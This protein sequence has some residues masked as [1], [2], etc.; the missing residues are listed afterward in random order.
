MADFLKELFLPMISSENIAGVKSLSV[1][2]TDP[3]VL[4][5]CLLIAA[6][7]TVLLAVISSPGLAFICQHTAA[8]TKKPFFDKYAKQL[9]TMATTLGG[10]FFTGIAAG[11]IHVAMQQPVIFEGPFRIPV[12]VTLVGVLS[13]FALLFA[14]TITWR[15]LRT[16]RGLHKLIGVLTELSMLTV[17]FLV[18]GVLRGL[19][20]KGHPVSASDSAVEQLLSLYIIPGSG[21]FW[22]LFMQAFVYGYGAAG[23]LGCCYL[24]LRRNR[25]DF[26]RDYYKFALSLSSVWAMLGTL[27]ALI[28]AGFMIWQYMPFIGSF[29]PQNVAFWCVL[30]VVVLPVLACCC[31]VTVVRAENPLRAKPAIFAAVPLA[32]G[33]LAAQVLLMLHFAEL[34]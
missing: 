28:P 4:G 5:T 3:L 29:A 21:V 20:I 26:G 2:L 10:I 6:V 11:C 13:A 9:A 27:L 14:Y 22:P 15:V 23:M 17:M 24:L 12:L 33:G 34:L 16:C 30:A 32:L 1:L 8:Q 25:D 19:L 18:F 31:W 7:V